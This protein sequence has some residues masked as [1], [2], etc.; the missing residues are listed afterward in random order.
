M[1]EVLETPASPTTAGA[2]AIILRL[3]LLTGA[4]RGEIEGLKWSEVDFNFGMLGKTTSRTGARVIPRARVAVGILEEQR[5]WV[6]RSRLWV[7]PA[8]RGEGRFDGLNKEWHRIRNLPALRTFAFT[9]CDASLRAWV[10]VGAWGCRSLAE[11]PGAARPRQRN[12][13]LTC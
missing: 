2:A 9:I 13:T 8:H 11:F 10:Q 3:L 6:D 4:R 7:L 1:G 12:D 5:R